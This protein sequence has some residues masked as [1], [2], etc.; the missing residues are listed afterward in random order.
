MRLAGAR[1]SKIREFRNKTPENCCRI[2]R[3]RNFS[4]RKMTVLA[5]S[6]LIRHL[7]FISRFALPAQKHE[8][9]C[10]DA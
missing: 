10:F 2:L 7:S 8:I 6:L 3:V 5:S 1:K 4:K 9:V